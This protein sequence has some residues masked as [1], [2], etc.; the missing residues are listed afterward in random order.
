MVSQAG[1]GEIRLAGERSDTFSQ[2]T[3]DPRWVAGA[4]GGGAYTPTIANGV[5]SLG[6]AEPV[7]VRSASQ[8]LVTSLEARVRFTAAAWEHVGW[9]DLNFEGVYLLFSTFNSAT[10]LFVRSYTPTGELRTDLGPI[11]T[12]FHDY[13]INRQPASATTDLISYYIDGVLRAQHTIGLTPPLYI[14]QSYVSGPALEIDAIAAYPNYV[15]AGTYQS[16]TLDAGNP[17]AQWT[18]ATW[19]ADVPAGTTLQLRTRT[20]SNGTTWSAWSAP[21]T[22]NGAPLSSPPGRYLQYLLELATTDPT[23]SPVVEAVTVR[24]SD[25]AAAT[26]PFAVDD[27]AATLQ[28]VP[29]AIDVLANDGDPDGG[30]I[31]IISVTQGTTG[32]VAVNPNQ[33][34]T[35]TPSSVVCGPDS[36][37]Y[38]ISDSSGNTV[39]ASVF[40]SVAC[41]SGTVTQTAWQTLSSCTVG[42]NAMATWAGDG[43]VRLAGMQSD[44]YIQ[45]TLDPA[46]WVA[47]A[48]GGGAY[49]P[50]VANGLLSLGGTEPVFVRSATTLPVT[51][52]EATVRFTGT[53]WQHVGWGQLNFEGVY[54]LFSTANSST[55]LYARSYTLTGELRTDLGPIPQG[56]RSYRIQRQPASAT[57][58]TVSYF[59]DGVLRAQHTIPTTPQ[60]FVYQSVVGP[61][62]DIDRIAVYP[63]Y[64]AAGSFQ[65][66][67]LDAGYASAVW[68][69][70]AWTAV[71]P[72]GAT[73]QLRTRT[74]TDGTTWSAWSGP[75]TVSGSPVSSP[76]GRYVQYLL[77]LTTPDPSQ[78]P[79]VNSVALD[80][81]PPE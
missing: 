5:L 68:T 74:S 7:F 64:V 28:G 51:T 47:G 29:I 34:L 66:C 16:C 3:L 63:S 38:T 41:L 18:S 4:W 42:T 77:D 15:A 10:N 80:F 53:P 49:T 33:T 69:A 20:S 36:F 19:V 52:L 78:S 2:G 21:I 26:P 23:R 14:Y 25:S 59:I 30:A 50:S 75:L 43:E 11:P 58:D 44:E 55:N 40:V 22:A 8:Q 81:D 27:A 79:V 57:T 6:A 72:P 45:A 32:A 9:G 12:G 13:R 70:A 35:Y 56:F 60:M 31:T 62:L 76:P 61:T 48:W 73:L 65:S 71:V 17:T 39:S 37:T 24:V 67:T 1:D 46:R 54:L